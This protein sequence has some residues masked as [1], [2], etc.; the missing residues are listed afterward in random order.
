MALRKGSSTKALVY[1]PFDQ[2]AKVKM[3][4]IP[5]SEPINGNEQERVI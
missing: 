3:S 1:H 2:P 4:V 5:V